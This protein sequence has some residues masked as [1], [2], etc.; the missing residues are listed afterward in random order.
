[1]DGTRKSGGR[2]TRA[3]GTRAQGQRSRL[4]LEFK[5]LS[6][7]MLCNDFDFYQQ[8]HFKVVEPI[9][10]LTVIQ[11]GRGSHIDVLCNLVQSRHQVI[12]TINSITICSIF[13][14]SLTFIGLL[15]NPGDRLHMLYMLVP[16]ILINNHIRPGTAI[17]IN[18]LKLRG[19]E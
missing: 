6:S 17:V 8:A 3:Q 14:F 11:V 15:L 13:F 1:M 18:K 5:Q 9:P 10:C 7:N 4:A 19:L 12:V 2:R 16:L